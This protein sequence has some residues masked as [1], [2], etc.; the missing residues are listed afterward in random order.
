[1]IED[2]G[3]IED[4]ERCSKPFVLSVGKNVKFLSSPLRASLFFAG[5]VLQKEEDSEETRCVFNF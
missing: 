1:L 5:S 2:L 3:L 4:P